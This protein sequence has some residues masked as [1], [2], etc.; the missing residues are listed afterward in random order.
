M[1]IT[2][3]GLNCFKIQTKN[4][5]L[6]TDPYSDKTGL[7]MPR[8]KADIVTISNQDNPGANNRKAITGQ[9]FVIDSPGE[10]EHTEI[11]IYGLESNGQNN[12]IYIM[13]AEGVF[14]AH[15][16]FLEKDLTDK[17]L[18]GLKEVDILLLPS[19]GLS[20]DKVSKIIGQVEPR[21][22]IPMNYKIPKLKTKVESLDK[23]TKALGVKEA[24]S[25]DK[26]KIVEKDLPQ[27]E[28]RTYILKPNL[29]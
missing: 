17:Q 15:L 21:I 22:I 3:L 16:G 14:I 7:T 28:T 24:E 6:I 27:E 20:T 5:L 8:F 19:T 13:E 11:F 1:Q 4:S 29:S 9:P 10:Y 12:T 25:L 26:L 18:D 2:Y 23:I